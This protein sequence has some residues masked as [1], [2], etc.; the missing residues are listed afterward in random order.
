MCVC[1]CERER[2]REEFLFSLF[3]LLLVVVVLKEISRTF[4]EHKA[5]M[6]VWVWKRAML[7]SEGEQVLVSGNLVR[8]IGVSPLC[9]VAVHF[10]SL[11]T[12]CYSKIF[13]SSLCIFENSFISQAD[14]VLYKV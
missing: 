9:N 4:L 5:T 13:E 7:F 12:D 8:K 11:E 6:Q 10:H 3:L 2:E 1:V 14:I